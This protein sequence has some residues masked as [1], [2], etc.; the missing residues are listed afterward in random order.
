MK[1]LHCRDAGFNCE[2]VVRANSEE[3]VLETAARHAQKA[4]GV[5]LSEENSRQIRAFIREE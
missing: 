5:T 4:H 3:E 2:A 1:V